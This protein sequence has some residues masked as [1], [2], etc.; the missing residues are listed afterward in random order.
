MRQPTSDYHATENKGEEGPSN[1]LSVRSRPALPGGFFHSLSR[2]ADLQAK[3]LL[4]QTLVILGTEFGLPARIND[5]RG[6]SDW[7]RQSTLSENFKTPRQTAILD[8][9][10]T[11]LLA[12]LQAMGLLSETLVVL[13]TEFGRTP[14]INCNDGWDDNEGLHV[15]ARGGISVNSILSRS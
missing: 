4:D 6:M 13:G 15:P 5:N 7:R 14:R 1:L 9:A 12:N 3:G 8:Q 10:L 2:L 11:A